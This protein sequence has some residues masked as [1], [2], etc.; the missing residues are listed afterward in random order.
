[1]ADFTSSFWNWFIA[2]PTILGILGC[3]WLVIHYSGA[4]TYGESKEGEP[5]GHVWD[6]DLQEIN[7]PLPRWWLNMFYATLI[8]GIIYLILYPGLGSWKGLLGWTEAGQYEAEMKQAEETYGPLFDKYLKVPV[9]ELAKDPKAVEM[10]RHLFATYCVGCHGSDAGGARGYPNL[11]DNDWLYGGTPEK[12]VE[13]ITNGRQGAMPAWEDQGLLTH[14]Q[15]VNAAE[16]VRGLSGAEVD[17]QARAKGEEVFKTNCAVCHGPDGKGNQALGA[18]NLTDDI[19]L[20]GGSQK[21]VI[22]SIAHG[23]SGR[24][25]AWGELLG[26]G[27]IHLLATYVYSLS[28]NKGP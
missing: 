18:P 21:R 12:I 14:E 6:G 8:F 24:M 17:P 9:A 26:K 27:K 4:R 23:R 28:H 2:V 20:Y 10:G 22:E 7:N 15:V 25:P 1:M 5:M 3:F 13:T 19:W 16:Y 11:R